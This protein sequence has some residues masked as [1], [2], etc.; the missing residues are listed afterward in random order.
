[1]PRCT[2]A[3]LSALSA[4]LICWP[5]YAVGN[6]MKVLGAGNASCGSWPQDRNTPSYQV[7]AQVGWVTGYITGFNSYAPNQSGDV[8]AG[9]D[10]DGELAWID[11]YCQAH[12]L[13]SLFRATS[14]LIR[15][16]ETRRR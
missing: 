3:L 13:D 7:T 9:T 1:M 8:S 16:L 11:S 12:P 10:L 2:F 14:A 5:M 15:E 4:V 6:P